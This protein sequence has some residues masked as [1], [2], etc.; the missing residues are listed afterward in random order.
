M[1]SL[2]QCFCRCDLT[3]N[4]KNL[5]GFCE[6][7]NLTSNRLNFKLFVNTLTLCDCIK[8]LEAMR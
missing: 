8:L 2:S 3:K 6:F 5:L 1:I 7:C 4:I